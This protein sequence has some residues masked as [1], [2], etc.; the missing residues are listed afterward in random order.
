MKNVYN[1]KQSF[2]NRFSIRENGNRYEF[3]DCFM[4]YRNGDNRGGRI[5]GSTVDQDG[6]EVLG[7]RVH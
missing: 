3:I 6:Y 1:Y 2:R 5:V 4:V 7:E